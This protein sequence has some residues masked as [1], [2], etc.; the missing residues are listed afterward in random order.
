MENNSRYGGIVVPFLIVTGNWHWIEK[1][2]FI[3]NWRTLSSYWKWALVIQDSCHLA[4]ITWLVLCSISLCFATK[5][6]YFT[7]LCTSIPA[8]NLL[9]LANIYFYVHVWY[10]P[11]CRVPY[12]FLGFSTFVDLDVRSPTH[13]TPRRATN[14]NYQSWERQYTGNVVK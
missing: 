6:A 8:R 11:S 3:S 5:R 12:Y 13:E 2:T 4:V 7:A 1:W 14:H 9:Q 10:N